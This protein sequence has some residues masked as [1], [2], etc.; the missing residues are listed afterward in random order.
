M[1]PR[2]GV[3]AV[4]LTL[5]GAL[6]GCTLG[7]SGAPAE[8]SSTS[9]PALSPVATSSA[10]PPTAGL[11]RY[12]GQRLDWTDCSDGQQ[13]ATLQVPLDYARPADRSI[14]LALLK[15]SATSEAQRR[16]SLV[17]NP[18]GPGR[19]GKDYAAVAEQALGP[20][21]GRAYDVVGF[22]PRGVG[23]STPVECGS[24]EQQNALVDSDPSP[25]TAAERRTTDRLIRGLGESCLRDSGALA[26]HVS[27]VEVAKDMDVLRAA[28][29]EPRLTYFGASYGTFIG[30]T[31]AELFP[32]KIDRMVLD[33]AI[34]PAASTVE[35][36]L[37]QARG[38]E[39]ALR[40][41]I[42]ACIEAGDCYLGDSVDEGVRRVQELL[43]DVETEPL[44]TSSG[45][46]LTAG[47]AVYGIWVP[48]YS[49]LS[50]PV[51]DAGLQGAFEGDGSVLMNLADQY[52]QRTAEGKYSTNSAEVFN[53]INCL[54]RDDGVPSSEVERYE[55]RFEKASPTF[56]SIFAYSISTC[57]SWPVHSG[58][59]PQP[60]RAEGSPPIMV[61]GTT[62]DPAT[63]LV[64][65]RALADQLPQG[66]LVTRDG[67]GH[68]GFRA[69][70]ACTDLAVERYLI[71]GVV[72]TKDVIC[73]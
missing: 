21:L 35:V 66:V 25:D 2:T 22:D 39:T 70:S 44:S 49:K 59:Q 7:S 57:A 1:A 17:I 30:A 54:D 6:G 15:V 9:R 51:L 37:V 42:G 28:L 48:L 40:A 12:Y 50:W 16:G 41:Y 27:T 56:G 32:D 53:A 23:E 20:E 62:R 67:D 10:P 26:R 18:G 11:R 52:L 8:P 24:D 19:S 29:G 55:P 36:N 73:S 46:E 68:L 65:S 45:R 61:V 31:Y 38:F 58:R 14:D 3:A 5:A 72:P 63:P 13:C 33:G 71:D 43:R 60:V 69:G 4:V 64:W 47:N 34:D